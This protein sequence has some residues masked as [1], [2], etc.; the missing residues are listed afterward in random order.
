MLIC[1]NYNPGHQFGFAVEIDKIFT[2]S[3]SNLNDKKLF[4]LQ[5]PDRM[6]P[7]S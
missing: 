7:I 1:S 3:K 2:S 4:F 6:D 5:D